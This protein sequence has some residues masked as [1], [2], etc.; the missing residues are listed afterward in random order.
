MAPLVLAFQYCV[1]YS[2]DLTFD[3]QSTV[4]GNDKIEACKYPAKQ[5]DGVYD[6]TYGYVETSTESTIY[7]D[8]AGGHSG[9]PLALDILVSECNLTDAVKMATGHGID[10]AHPLKQAYSTND[11]EGRE[12]CGIR[13]SGTLRWDGQCHQIIN[14]LMHIGHPNQSFDML[15]NSDKCPGW[16]GIS[17]FAFGPY[18]YRFDDWCHKNNFVNPLSD[19]QKLVY[20]WIRQWV[21]DDRFSQRV[22]YR[23]TDFRNTCEAP[24]SDPFGPGTT[25]LQQQL[26]N[27]GVD[28][29]T[30]HNMFKDEL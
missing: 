21:T 6:H 13:A 26:V 1:P 16:Y 25:T 3:Y 11:I 22:F 9:S 18:G 27:E 17:R 29:E 20:D 23:I 2:M 8:T 30:V 24:D 14:R 7:F 5:H 19:L 10:G 4:D 12:T 15:W 28:P